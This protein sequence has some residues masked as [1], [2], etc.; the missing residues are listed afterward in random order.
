LL[1]SRAGIAGK[2]GLALSDHH[3]ES[4]GA[5][6]PAD[7]TRTAAVG[8]AGMRRSEIWALVLCGV[9]GA[10][11]MLN[12]LALFFLVEHELH[13]AD[14]HG[15]PVW[16]L[17]VLCLSAGLAYLIETL[18][19]WIKHP[20][21]PRP[22][23]AEFAST[24]V[25]ILVSE[26]LLVA[27]HKWSGNSTAFF[28]APCAD[29]TH[30]TEELVAS[31]FAVDPHAAFTLRVLATMWVGIGA[32]LAAWIGYIMLRAP[33]N[34]RDSIAFGAKKG[35]LAGFVAAPLVVLGCILFL[36]LV[37]IGE[38]AAY[39]PQAWESYLAGWRYAG[40]DLDILTRL[41][42][43]Q[44]PIFA[45]ERLADLVRY[46]GLWA[47]AC[48]YA[49]LL[50]A[51]VIVRFRAK[52][53]YRAWPFTIV[54]GI[55][56]VYLV[57]PVMQLEMLG[58]DS[59]LQVLRVPIVAALVWGVPAV[60]LSSLMPL[61]RRFTND[62]QWWT[63]IAIVMALLLIA[64][65]L[66]RVAQPGASAAIP[67][68]LLALLGVW[69]LASAFVFARGEPFADQWPFAGLTVALAVGFITSLSS[70]FVGIWSEINA[71][72]ATINVNTA[73]GEYS[74]L[75]QHR[76][77]LLTIQFSPID[78]RPAE[79]GALKDEISNRLRQSADLRKNLR[80]EPGED[81]VMCN[82]RVLLQ[83]DLLAY[84]AKEEKAMLASF[85][86]YVAASRLEAQCASSGATRRLEIAL[87]ASFGFWV[88]LGLLAAYRRYGRS[89][90]A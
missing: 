55:G 82:A 41:F 72:N 64:A 18:R 48:G 70:T 17:L 43:V 86:H 76:E 31:L 4:H 28:S 87:A 26:L 78:R 90:A 65:A 80:C 40:R 52:S 29:E 11:G 38:A 5:G 51:A 73:I 57:L 36:R 61:W 8:A 81:V 37:D 49:V 79:I 58:W 45:L 24:F 54:A 50:I 39:H 77:R 62:R 89:R 53:S 33:E 88:T 67:W 32:G 71:I 10:I 34:A 59:V 7:E 75:R 20:G 83:S 19:H 46:F 44:L 1:S 68:W 85:D 56:I 22:S 12:G 25:V 9:V 14:G 2:R 42:S 74:C 6:V 16:F 35:A 13:E 23:L 15:W 84:C 47:V 63:V 21:V 3:A 69:S 30:H 66:F 27:A 60:I